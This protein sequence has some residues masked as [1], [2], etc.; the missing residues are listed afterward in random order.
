VSLALGREAQRAFDRAASLTED[1]GT[2]AE[3]LEHA[4]RA[5]WLEADYATAQARIDAAIALYGELGR[6]GDAARA[7]MLAAELL[8]VVGLV[9]ESIALG[10]RALEGL[11]EAGTD[12]AAALALLARLQTLAGNT[13]AG[14]ALTDDALALAEPL[15]AWETIAGALQTRG[16]ILLEHGRANEG[17]ALLSRSL[18][19]ALGHDLPAV[20]LRAYNNLAW[21][22]FTHDRFDDARQALDS[23]LAIA[24]ARGDRAWE[25]LLSSA[26]ITVDVLQGRWDE[27]V[28]SGDLLVASDAPLTEVSEVIL[29]VAML[30]AARGDTAS[31]AAAS[32]RI[33]PLL[34]SN[35]IQARESAILVRAITALAEGRPAQALERALPVA[36]AAHPSSRRE[37]YVVSG[38]AAVALGDDDALAD[39]VEIVGGRPP[40]LS[41]PAM[42]AQ[43]RRFAGL[44]AARRGDVEAAERHLAAAADGLRQIGAPFLLAKVLLEHGELLLGIDRAVD[45]LPLVEQARATFARLGATPW[46]ERA[47]RVLQPLEQPQ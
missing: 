19:V 32:A 34:E 12:R 20:A 5:A 14:L 8:Y 9:D 35:D 46:R 13:E 33:A 45:A 36:P 11:P 16:V 40:G 29:H 6:A 41:S 7:T 4:G 31:L 15:H 42:H 37:I 23:A 3:L 24:R 26:G 39:V 1:D 47:E 21:T 10:Q 25:G 30:Q 38:E 2:R 44:L 22:A 27:A 43:A 18:E 28:E 17:D